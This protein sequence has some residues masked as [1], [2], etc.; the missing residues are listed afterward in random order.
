MKRNEAITLISLVIT[1]IILIILAGVSINVLFSTDGI[2]TKTK[3][4]KE[5]YKIEQLSEGLELVKS[6]AQLNKEDTDI[7]VDEYLEKI[8]EEGTVKFSIDKIE[9]ENSENA[10]ITVDKDYLFLIEKRADKNLVI[11][12]QGKASEIVINDAIIE[13]S[14]EETQTSLPIT[15]NAKVT[16]ENAQN[17]L[18]ISACRYEINNSNS[19][20]GANKDSY[21]GTF[22]S[23]RETI[24]IKPSDVGTWYLHVL[25]VDKA[26]RTKETIKG[27][28]EI[29][30][31]THTHTGSSSAGGG[32]YT[33]AV[34]N[35]QACTGKL[36]YIGPAVNSGAG[37]WEYGCNTCKCTGI[38]R[39]I[40]TAA[41]YTCEHVHSNGTIN[42]YEINC[43]K[44]VNA[45]EGYLVNY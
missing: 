38:A 40:P 28:I 42:H 15:L 27:P 4:A 16:H 21:T 8:Q 37:W 13:L 35:T 14:G 32:C 19:T 17:R 43:G 5:K 24:T 3:E 29:E 30:T 10:Y 1:I 41:G 11:I 9:K 44:A 45:I 12:Y 23:N 36:Y 6:M 2:V 7:T 25:T 26:G 18:D 33:K 20:L 31:K 39:S 34:Y 22:S